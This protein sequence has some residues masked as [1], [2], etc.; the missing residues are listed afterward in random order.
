[1]RIYL[2]GGAV[3]DHVMGVVPKDRDYV[4]VGS[5]P[6]EMLALG[7]EQVGASF[8]VFLKDGEEYALARQE[9]KTGVGYSGFETSF[10]PTITLE[11]DLIRR[12]LTM[13]A[14]AMDLETGEI[15]DPYGGREHIAAGMLLHT[16]DAFAEDPVR[17]LR[18]ARFAAR[19]QFVV[20]PETVRLMSKVVPEID[21]VPAERVFAEFQ[22]GLAEDHPYEMIQAL[23]ECDASRSKRVQPYLRA[24]LI[25]SLLWITKDTPMHVRFALLSSSFTDKD[26]EDCKIPTD[27]AHVSKTVHANFN[28]LM[29]FDTIAPAAAVQLMDKMRTFSDPA[30]SERVF[31]VIKTYVRRG[32]N[33]DYFAWK[34]AVNARVVAAGSIDA[35]AIA[36]SCIDPKDIRQ[37]IFNARVAA[38][39]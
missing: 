21:H 39:S 34:H 20:A 17:V 15:I 24:W 32:T 37:A 5:T 33:V 26:Y 4:V 22:K 23:H 31:D 9:R 8:P 7:Y 1:M 25:R 16:S 3:R 29:A 6:E 19:Y 11:D 10:D 2:V 18:T 38:L 36:A 28:D 30:H 12:D 27:L 14:M 35:A 13:N